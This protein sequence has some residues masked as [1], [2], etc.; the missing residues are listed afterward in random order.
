MRN[1]WLVVVFAAVGCA[2]SPV[3]QCIN[4]SGS[5]LSAGECTRAGTAGETRLVLSDSSSCTG[6]QTMLIEQMGCALKVHVTAKDGATHDLTFDKDV[7]WSDSGATFTWTPKRSGPSIL[8]G[9]AAESRT[10]T[11]ALAPSGDGLTVTSSWDQRGVALLFVPYHNH[12]EISC[13]MKRAQ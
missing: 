5:Y 8:P 10:L 13:A 1:A 11:F 6:I 7:E 2:S 4:I 3:Q 9:T 12:R